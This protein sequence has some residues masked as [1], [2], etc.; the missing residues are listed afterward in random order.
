LIGNAADYT[1]LKSSSDPGGFCYT[2]YHFQ[3]SSVTLPLVAAHS[4]APTGAG[5]NIASTSRIFAQQLVRNLPYQGLHTDMCDE[6]PISKW[7]I[8]PLI[9]L[10]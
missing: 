2:I 1:I 4:T 6:M 10:A 5:S 3:T 9:E 7:I 8:S